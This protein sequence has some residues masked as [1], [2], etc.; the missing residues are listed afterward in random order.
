MRVRR[1][2]FR[3][4]CFLPLLRRLHQSLRPPVQKVNT[5]TMA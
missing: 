2:L 3:M 1:R 4:L 5:P